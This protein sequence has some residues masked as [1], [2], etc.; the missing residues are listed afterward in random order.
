[1]VFEISIRTFE[2][3]EFID[4]TNQINIVLSQSGVESGMC[5]VFIPHTTAAI[6]I[7][8]NADPDVRFDMMNEFE[9]LVPTENGYAHSEGNSAAHIKSSML[10]NSEYMIVQGGQLVLGQ[11]Q[12]VYLTEFDGP[13]SR[14]VWIKVMPDIIMEEYDEVD[15]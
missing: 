8:E 7:N 11:W 3:V 12:G 13:R 1:M 15:E 5:M 9:A 2:P 4:I 14:K 10:G 6:T